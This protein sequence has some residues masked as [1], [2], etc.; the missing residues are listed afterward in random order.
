MTPTEEIERG[1]LAA[2]VLENP[3]FREAFDQMRAEVVKKWRSEKDEKVRDWLWTLDQAT[4]R[5]ESILTK[6]M[7]DGQ[8]AQKQLEQQASRLE[9]LGSTLKR[10][11]T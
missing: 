2:D 1:R 9:R 11:F 6:A 5:V 3:V 10:N 8:I 7:Q 4:N